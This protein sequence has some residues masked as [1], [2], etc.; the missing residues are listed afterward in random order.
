MIRIWPFRLRLRRLSG[1]VLAVI[2]CVA[3][4]S[5]Q[6][7]GRGQAAPAAPAAALV[8]P[9]SAPATV[10]VWQ[11]TIAIPT[12]A[13]GAPDVN[14]PFDLF[15]T[16]RFNY[17]YTL[18]N[19]LTDR[20]IEKTWRA[21][22]LENDY[23]KCL[24]L[25]DLGG[26][27]YSCTDKRNGQQLFYANPSIKLAG[28]AYRG[29]W[30]AFGVEFNF[31][32]SHNWM[33][34]SPVDFATTTDADGGASVWV[35][36]IDRP[37]GMQWRVQL[38]LAPG[39]AV[40][41]QH[42]TLYNRSDTRHRF[43]WWTNAGVQVWDDSKI[44]YP[45]EF[46]ASHGF[47][48]VDTW[49]IDSAGHDLSV[50]GHHK[51]G[52]VSRFSHGSRE[53]YMGVYHP[54]TK[55][56]IVHYSSPVDLPSKKLWSWSSDA[57]GLDWK[58]ALS[59][60]DSA[61]VEIQAGPFRNQETYG[62]LE[63]QQTLAF[64]E[65]WMPMLDMDGLSKAT[66]DALVNVTRTPEK[67]GFVTINVAMNVTRSMAGAALDM[68][69]GSRVVA[70][71]RVDVTPATTLRRTYKGQPSAGTYTLRLADASG[72]ELV[73]HTEGQYDV[74][75][76]ADIQ[77]GAQP[78]F[79]PPP[80]ASRTDG[81]YAAL[82]QQ[83]ELD[84][85]L[86][87]AHAT[88]REGLATFPD[89]L[90][91]T[92]AA[93]RLMVGLKQFAAAVPLLTKALTRV[94]NDRETAYYLAV[95][96]RALG[97][98]RQADLHW[99]SAQQ[100]G[101]FAAASNLNLAATL[102]KA[103]ERD[104]AMDR[105]GRAMA[106][107]PEAI[108][109][110]GLEVALLRTAGQVEKAR[111]RAAAWRVR[112]PTNSLLR[113]EAVRLG[114]A[115]EALWA[116]LAADPERI[117]EVAVD[118]MRF[119][120]YA[121][122]IELL[123]RSFPS[124]PDVVTEPGMPRPEAYPLIAYYRGFCRA[125]L[126]QSPEADYAL[127]SSQ[128]TTYVFPHRPESLEVLSDAVKRNAKD[129][130]A[131]FLR[132]SLYLSGGMTDAALKAWET[133]RVL[134]PAIPTLHRNMGATLAATGALDNAIAMFREGMR[135]DATNIGVY[136]G[137]EQALAQAG[138]PAAD[139]AEALLA[140]PD[141]KALPA[142][143]VYKLALLL[144]DAG[145]FDEAERQFSGRFFPRVEG[146]INVR[147]IW[148]EARAR[149]A[150]AL[151]QAKD[152]PQ[153]LA[154]IAGL[155]RPVPALSFTNDGLGP[156]LKQPK[157][158]TI[159]ESVNTPCGA[160]AAVRDSDVP[161]GFGSW[162]ADTL[163]NHRVVLNVDAPASVVTAHLPWRRRDL[164]PERKHLI[165]IDATTGGRVANVVRLAITREAGDIA[166][167]APSAGEYDVYYLPYLGAGR[168]NY[169]K[170]TYPEPSATADDRWL[171]AHRL[172][173]GA[174][175]PSATTSFPKASVV[176]IQAIDQLNSFF[177][178]EVIATKAETAALDAAHP[179]APFL[180]FA[181]NRANPIKMTDDLPLRWIRRGPSAPFAGEAMRGEFYAFQLG[182]YASR[183]AID[184]VRVQFGALNAKGGSGSIAASAFRC[185]NLG[186]V[187]SAAKPFTR[188]VRI[189]PGKVQALWCGVQVPDA[190]VA[191]EYAGKLI[192]SS[193][194]S[195]PTTVPFALHVSTDLAVAHGDD[196][197]ARLSR[198]RWLDSTL[199]VDDGL[200]KPYT[201]VAVA[202]SKRQVNVLGREVTLDE[203]GFPLKIESRF[204]IEMT[205]QVEGKG[206]QV[207]SGPVALVVASPDVAATR[208]KGTGPTFTKQAP[209]AAAWRSTGTAG[210]LSMTT[211]AQMDFDGNIEFQVHVRASASTPIDDIRLDIPLSADVARYMMGLGVKGGR[212]PATLDWKWDVKN[213]Q[214][215]AWIG[216]INAGLQFTL[217]D[218]AYVRPLNT[219]F[220]TLKP[221]VMPVSWYNGGKGGCRLAEKDASTYLV[222]CYSG[223]RT[224][225]KDESLAFNFRLLLTPFKTIDPK[226]QFSTRFFHAFKPVDDIVATG[227][228]VVNVH[229]A[230]PI[231][232]YINYPFFRPGEMKAYIDQA[233]ANA[234][235][236]KIY[237]T[238]R[239]L[240]NRAPEVFA[241]RSLGD[242]VFAPGAGGGF[243]WLQEHLGSNYIA[244][245]FVPELKDAAIV[246][247][248]VSRWHNFY[249]EGLDWLARNVGIDGLYIDDVAFDRLTMKRV[250]K[251]LDR[252]R[253]DAMIDLHSA[254]QFNVRDG[255]AS[256]AN[257]YLEH[258][259]Y[260]NRLWFGEYFDYNSAPDYWLTEI[261]GIPFGL[262]GEMLE[263]GGNPWRGM[264]YGMTGRL[265]WSGDPRPMWK[266]WDEFGLA[267]S[268]MIGYWVPGHPVRTG[269]DDV[270]ATAYVREG[271]TMIALATWA[272]E[273]VDAR[274]AVD[275]KAIGL[276]PATVSITA[277]AIDGFQIGR[278]FDLN[279]TI[280]I[281]PGKGWLLVL[282]SRRD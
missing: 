124:G 11:D 218:D 100:Y 202:A 138:K 43:Y 217:K 236:V 268:R 253:P 1:G 223:A 33:T 273:K 211:D 111:A 234:M 185:I 72:R 123:G 199:A 173:P 92:R 62:F 192:V 244:A 98:S 134:R 17:P 55:S 281:E 8:A 25:P 114:A 5:P 149:R 20:R 131:H 184:D 94:S 137:L 269:R 102:W 256:S 176:E 272:G 266:A 99:E 158:A 57:D 130:V 91:L 225:A 64:S 201:A 219:N 235:R 237:Y 46:T 97:H 122:A 171:A 121:D 77:T 183:Q 38:R 85:Q 56:G 83:Q 187:D 243:S 152:C 60:N 200:V 191:G 95:A 215:S 277:P 182:V 82:G 220:Y 226:A 86:L 249:V 16:A 230:N 172:G 257:L 260:L 101:T 13:E 156:F 110:G 135:Y 177:P 47:S 214:D 133:S 54:K 280:P 270:L 275:W 167:E 39:R 175:G 204:A 37:Y 90:A 231:N 129:A 221:L 78:A 274:L 228:N 240:T 93:G 164:E 126:G 40:L 73:R 165:V 213:N 146:G 190:A 255:F 241:L 50:V 161:Y 59:D 259:P 151:A 28:I 150:Q 45:M 155:A 104:E 170:V 207:L 80:P 210:P 143:L 15:Q 87:V 76:R 148:L 115:D 12:Y 208:W 178:M 14:P 68:L 112:D 239:E 109:V 24:I 212:R 70:R 168:S 180:V 103:G 81:D 61:Y 282:S 157:L 96:E 258:F 263:G 271:K 147:Q 44:L 119:G 153:A 197:P 66:R 267:D 174:V 250:R 48:F 206:R 136:T 222:S 113:V 22:W 254:N 205:H 238:V 262:M 233:H 196:D 69:D 106:A 141:Q 132:G 36:N 242:E 163:G 186:G 246:N 29:A 88:Y 2:A 120:L 189:E 209:G 116:H 203:L 79:Q 193:R 216:D 23:L 265:P 30:A 32:V 18:R 35:G 118:Y 75:S 145:R 42:T 67:T 276:D 278:T 4:W 9:A 194:G 140:F 108:R 127:A 27:L 6:A 128:S 26:H 49:P 53:P 41:E 34:V 227:A 198:L 51:Y 19:N 251:V 181:E 71:E 162:D 31:P 105:L 144:A 159:V 232:P 279:Q 188:S 261:S 245:W 107:A 65:Y 247:S 10:R 74:A 3:W 125:Q 179:K 252:H 248:G 63:P 7:L 58:K 166:F 160:V 89:S 264:V 21:L 154:V 142:A 195:A 117:L 224:M 84:G 52:P 169:P 229:H 139:R